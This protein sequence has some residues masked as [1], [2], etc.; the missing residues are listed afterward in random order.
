MKIYFN[1]NEDIYDS[2][3]DGEEEE[4]FNMKP[5]PK[6]IEKTQ[7]FDTDD[8]DYKV[9]RSIVEIHRKRTSDDKFSKWVEKNLEHLNSL[10]K[11]SMI[12][13]SENEFYNYIYE[14]SL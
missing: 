13:C 12:E 8:F 3:S 9:A 10:Y 4:V 14:N 11:L 1:D 5:T 7:R 6:K 2:E